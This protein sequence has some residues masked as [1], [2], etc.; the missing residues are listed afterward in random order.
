M[1]APIP[2]PDNRFTVPGN[3]W[4]LVHPGGREPTVAVVIAHYN[5]QSELDLTLEALRLQDYPQRLITVVVAD[6]GSAQ[7]PVVPAGVVV[8]RQPDEGFRAAAVR[9]L[10]ARAADAE[11]LCFLD[12]DTVP[13]PGYVRNIV[14]LPAVLP[15]ALVVGR[16]RHAD[17][18]GLTPEDLPRWWAGELTP[19]ELTEPTWL[20]DEYERSGDLLRL[21][22]RSYRYLISS[23]MC[24]SAE[25]FHD[26]GGFDESFVGYGGE[27]W[28]FAHRALSGGAVLH[29][30]RGA[31]A[32]HHGPDWAGRSVEDRRTQKNAE[33]LALARRIT[34]PD[35]RTH[36]LHYALP[37][38]AVRI[39]GDGH[40]SASLLRTVSCF[41]HSD[42]GIWVDDGALLDDVGTDDPRLHRGDIPAEVLA[43]CRFVVD[44]S[45]RAVLATP[46][47][48]ALLRRCAIPGVG[49]VSASTDGTEVICRSSW[50]VNRARRRAVTLDQISDAVSL[51]GAELGLSCGEAVPDLSW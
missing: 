19:P 46:A 10:G 28:E 24:C 47:L 9:N 32:W 6:D 39:A 51:S 50:A 5:Q 38:V 21:D 11:I 18:T 33:A 48:T 7:A 35:A 8:V 14:A 12:A 45:G 3:R 30:A 15:D 16:R 27:D 26:L 49:Q 22:H 43:R 20:R 31:V 2:L 4:D 41:L 13:E 1:T 34:D 40:T 37:D 36:G 42:A 25:L 44:V 29:H 23:V 17:L